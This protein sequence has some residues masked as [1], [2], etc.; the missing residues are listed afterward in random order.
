MV[1]IYV[2]LFML[3]TAAMLIGI[4]LNIA[5]WLKGRHDLKGSIVW[6]LKNIFSVNILKLFKR[7]IL[8]IFFQIRF[9]KQDKLRWIMKVLLIT[10]YVGVILVDHIIA[11]T[12]VPQFQGMSDI[13]VFFYAPFV[14]SYYIHA[15][16]SGAATF[17][18]ID[19]T[20]A[21]LN[22]LFDIMVIAGWAIMIYRRFVLKAFPIAT[23]IADKVALGALGGWFI[24]KFIGE[25]ASLLA[26]NVSSDVAKHWFVAYGISKVISPFVGGFATTFNEFMWV[27][28][29]LMLTVLFTSIP[30][31]RKLWHIFMLPFVM[32]INALPHENETHEDKKAE[33]DFTSKQL[34]EMDACVKCQ[35]CTDN[36][37]VYKATKNSEKP[38]L[39]YAYINSHVTSVLKAEHLPVYFGH[40]VSEAEKEKFNNEIYNCLLCAR[41]AEVCPSFI[42]TRDLGIA[43]RKAQ[44]HLGLTP[45]KF[46]MAKDAILK[47]KNVANFPNSERAMWIDFF[48]PEPPEDYYQ[49]DKA[50]V[51]Y[52]T[53][54]MAS[55]SPQVQDIPAT[56][57]QIFE[58]AGV[59]FTLL[60][61][62]EHCCGYPLMILGMKEDVD[63]LI[64]HNV[65]EI[66][67][68]GA[69]KVVF[70]CPS[71]YHT[72]AHEYPEI[73]GVE[74]IHHTQFIKQLIED[75]KIKLK[76]PIDTKAAYHDPCDL[77][78]NSGEYEAPREI[79]GKLPGIDIKEFPST[80]ELALCCGGGGDVEIANPD[81]TS[82]VSKGIIDEAEEI[83]ID[84]IITACQQCKRVIK[85]AADKNAKGKFKVKDISEV[86]LEAM[87]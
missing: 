13:L 53:G 14:N 23:D 70:S 44:Y 30:F 59:D 87:K 5:Y 74:L 80:R 22:D 12:R 17:G 50:E 27:L 49:K 2:A 38:Y 61:E 51:V 31:N 82:E 24:F 48:I 52:F 34:I 42:E 6:A 65:E 54:C 75:G 83:G 11:S 56:V 55:F 9:Y 43:V 26:F 15:F 40:R 20:Y 10:G 36:C 39:S 84:T 66:K 72:F 1:P 68:R 45:K 62:N 78:R 79:I 35:L 16:A 46:G 41:C 3:S 7:A 8:G 60:G 69:K 67:K 77:G 64:K 29:A 28:S 32:L 85:N 47:E 58:K 37:Q 76:K 73:E 71:C 4:L 21:F 57:V 18:P 33:I 81:L 86:V 63:E 25:A 19:I